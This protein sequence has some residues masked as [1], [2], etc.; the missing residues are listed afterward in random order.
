MWSEMSEFRV[1]LSDLH[2]ESIKLIGQLAMFLEENANVKVEISG[3]EVVVK[4][5]EAIK[6]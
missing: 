2:V 3:N 1:D 5:E 4:S 6:L